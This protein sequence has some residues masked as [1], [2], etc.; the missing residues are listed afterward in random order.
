MQKFLYNTRLINY[1]TNSFPLKSR[2]RR[3][4]AVGAE[5]IHGELKFLL[6][7]ADGKVG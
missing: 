7:N 6:P 2:C 1:S 3:S 5:I 4:A